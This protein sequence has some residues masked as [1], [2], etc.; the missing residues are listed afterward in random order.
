MKKSKIVLS[1]DRLMN[2]LTIIVNVLFILAVILLGVNIDFSV[3]SK[4]AIKNGLTD[5]AENL[6]IQTGAK[7]IDVN[8]YISSVVQEWIS[9]KKTKS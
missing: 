8:V 4:N 2:V 6:K 3:N 9:L 5:M 1:G 7:S